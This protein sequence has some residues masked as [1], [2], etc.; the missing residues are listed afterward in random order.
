MNPDTMRQAKA[1]F[2]ATR[3]VA[4]RAKNVS[5][6]I[7]PPSIF[8]REL[9]SGYKGA[10]ISF[11]SQNIHFENIGA[12]TGEIA[13][14]MVRDA[15]AAYALVGHAERRALGETN[16]ETRAKVNAAIA[17]KLMPILC[18]GERKRDHSGEH[19]DF[20]KE[21]LKIG[22]KDVSPAHIAKT[23]IAYE[24]VWEIGASE[25]MSPALMHEMAIF[26]RKSVVAT[27]GEKGMKIRILYGGSV[28]E[29]NAK[30]MMRDG[31]VQGL[32]VG[33]ASVDAD[34]FA[35]LIKSLA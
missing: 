6:V 9:A 26:I 31:D 17:A 4:D 16:E 35:L 10:K 13:P 27:H 28:D 25:A 20:V 19:F 8:L 34:T 32:L 11:A 12:H 30:D 7:A 23:I 18:V 22:L 5:I 1:L 3:R 14:E 33:R 21:Q 29:T 2:E 24:P 15:K